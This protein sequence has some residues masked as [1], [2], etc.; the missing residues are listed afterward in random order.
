MAT[1]R[2]LLSN[3]DFAAFETFKQNHAVA[4]SRV[5]QTMAAAQRHLKE[6][7]NLC[8]RQRL[9]QAAVQIAAPS[10]TA[11]ASVPLSPK[12]KSATVQLPREK[13]ETLK[14]EVGVAHAQIADLRNKL[15]A[16]G[17]PRAA[18]DVTRYV[19]QY[20]QQRQWGIVWRERA[21]TLAAACRIALQVETQRGVY[22]DPVVLE[23]LHQAIGAGAG[24][25][26]TEWPPVQP[27]PSLTT[28]VA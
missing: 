6:A 9:T 17:G 25:G 11:T 3:G 2:R 26:A 20:Q 8:N 7:N 24:L 10:T 21:K 1:E 19:E 28:N 16:A 5:V 18:K 12:P 23:I 4:V 13:Y 15:A 22:A 27:L 14:A